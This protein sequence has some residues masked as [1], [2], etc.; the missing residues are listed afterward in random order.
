MAG[1]DIP[2]ALQ[3]SRVIKEARTAKAFTQEKLAEIIGVEDRTI[4]KWESG[5][6]SPTFLH[7]RMLVQVLG[8]QPELLGLQEQ[9]DYSWQDAQR[10]VREIESSLDQG[11]FTSALSTASLLVRN[12]TRQTKRGESELGIPL[13]RARYLKGHAL[14]I[15]QNDAPLALRD[16]QVMERQAKELRDHTLLCTALTYQGE[17]HRRMKDYDKALRV[18]RK[19]LQEPD[20]ESI[21]NGNVQQLLARVYIAKHDIKAAMEAMG[22]AEEQAF[23]SQQHKSN[24]YVCFNLCS[25]YIDYAKIYMG[26]GDTDRSL[27]YIAKAEKLEKRGRVAPRWLIPI[28]LLKGEILISMVAQDETHMQRAV[29]NDPDYLEGVRFVQEG[30]LLAEKHGHQRQVQRALSLANKFGQRANRNL[31]ISQDLGERLREM[32]SSFL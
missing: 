7:R 3:T 13:N 6:S 30:H 10:L 19:A 25:V 17:M 18:M 21:V 26:L 24:L 15:V 20:V 2:L 31:I 12:L 22:K 14:S 16:F 27:D 23:R 11:T 29:L 4:R 9:T 5:Q 28:L 8:I 32:P 1:Y